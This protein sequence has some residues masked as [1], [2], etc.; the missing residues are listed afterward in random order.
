[1]I[2]E[3]SAR[4]SPIPANRD[5]TIRRRYRDVGPPGR[6]RPCPRAPNLALRDEG[7]LRSRRC[8]A[9]GIGGHCLA[10]SRHGGRI[11]GGRRLARSATLAR[12]DGVIRDGMGAP[13]CRLSP[14]SSCPGTTWCTRAAS[15]MPV[16][17]AAR[18]RGHRSCS[19][20]PRS[21][22]RRWRRCSSSTPAGSTSTRPP[23]GTCPSSGLPTSGPP[24]ASR[25]AKCFSRPPGCLRPRAARS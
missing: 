22:S 8:C 12:M 14:S 4:P 24:T 16:R 6:Q 25:Y 10:A 23:V 11:T 17:A 20:R 21:R 18:R 9:L 15:A 7:G 13:G 2:D 19:V 1:M 5:R 3:T